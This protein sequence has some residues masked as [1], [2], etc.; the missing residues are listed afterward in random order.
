MHKLF[1]YRL[2]RF[3]LEYVDTLLLISMSEILSAQPKG[4]KAICHQANRL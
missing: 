1:D 2:L 4:S 3:S